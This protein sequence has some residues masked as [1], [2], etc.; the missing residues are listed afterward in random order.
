MVSSR[1]PSVWSSSLQGGVSR[2]SGRASAPPQQL[3]VN[4]SL[5]GTQSS[6]DESSTEED[7]S[8]SFLRTLR[9]GTPP[10]PS[11]LRQVRRSSTSHVVPNAKA[12]DTV[13]RSGRTR[14]LWDNFE[15]RSSKSEYN[16]SFVGRELAPT[17]RSSS[18]VNLVAPSVWVDQ[19]RIDFSSVNPATVDLTRETCEQAAEELNFMAI[20]V[21]KLFKRSQAAGNSELTSLLAE[22]VSR[23]YHTLASIRDPSSVAVRTP[24]ASAAAQ[25]DPHSDPSTV[26]INLL[27]QYSDRLVSIVEQRMAKEGR[28]STDL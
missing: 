16:L 20:L 7:S 21:R 4:G 8:S 12:T 23:T 17:S 9:P 15:L 2:R 5:Q 13:T 24:K 18:R 28:S 14:K 25:G 10:K 19:K 26:A 27:Q 3:R 11:I 6:D 1:G 22:G